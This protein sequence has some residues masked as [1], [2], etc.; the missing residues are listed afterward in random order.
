MFSL[1]TF[2]LT[3]AIIAVPNKNHDIFAENLSKVIDEN[4]A[5]FQNDPDKKK[6]AAIL[7][8]IGK[9]ESSLELDSTGDHGTSFCWFQINKSIG[10]SEELN[11]DPYK[12]AK[13][14][15]DFLKWSFKACSAFPVALY[16]SGPNACDNNRA[17]RIS[18]DRM[19]LASWILKETEKQLIT[20]SR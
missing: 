16:A 7:I 9:R 2:I 15:Y 20:D 13:M 12:C 5:L 14:A 18:R 3:G 10:G 4:P 19:N 8:A 6:T 11:K 1:Y 17:Q